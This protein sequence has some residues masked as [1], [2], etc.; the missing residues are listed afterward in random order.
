M[1]RIVQFG[2][3]AS[4]LAV[5]GCIGQS[6]SGENEGHVEL[7]SHVHQKGGANASTT[8]IDNGLT[9]SASGDLAG[10]GEG[11]VLVTLTARGNPTAT[12][13]NPSGANEPSGQNP[14]EVVLTGTQSIPASEVKN[15]NT[16]FDVTTQAPQSPIPRAP[17]CPN[18]NWTETI[19]DVSFTS[20]TIVVRQSNHTVLTISCSFSSPTSDGVVASGDVTCTAQ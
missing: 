3:L 16:P 8:F 4:A 10:L 1:I 6:D 12:C 7:A 19:D 11:D 14:A 18:K 13:T 17:E 2:L 9:L 5:T 15:G 20:A